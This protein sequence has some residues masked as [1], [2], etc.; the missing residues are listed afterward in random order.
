MGLNPWF[1]LLC[2]T[3]NSIKVETFITDKI[4]V[5]ICLGGVVAANY[6]SWEEKHIL[7]RMQKEKEKENNFYSSDGNCYKFQ[8]AKVKGNT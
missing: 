1:H 6:F 3:N 5:N 2:F 8:S 7:R 4:R